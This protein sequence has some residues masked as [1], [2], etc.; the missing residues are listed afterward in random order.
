MTP[1]SLLSSPF[2]RNK[3]HRPPT[4]YLLLAL[5]FQKHQ[6]TTIHILKNA[7]IHS[8]PAKPAQ[9]LDK[10]PPDTAPANNRTAPAALRFRSALSVMG[11]ANS[12]AS[13]IMSQ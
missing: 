12:F 5:G 4:F 6:A 3:S 2:H 1:N 7:A 9:L 11:E 10:N 8:A 13:L